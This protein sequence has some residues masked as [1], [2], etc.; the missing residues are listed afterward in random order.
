MAKNHEE[1]NRENDYNASEDNSTTDIDNGNSVSSDE[2]EVDTTACKLWRMHQ[3]EKE[4]SDSSDEEEIDHNQYLYLLNSR[5][6]VNHKSST[7]GGKK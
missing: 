2:E 5:I 1:S 4:D 7:A 3:M 6:E